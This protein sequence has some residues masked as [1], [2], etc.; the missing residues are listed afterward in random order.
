MAVEEA[1]D[2]GAAIEDAEAFLLEL[3]RDGPVPTRAI[4]A[5]AKAHGHA[6]R[7]VA[8]AKKQLGIKAIKG[9]FEAGW[10]W[11][12]PDPP[13]DANGGSNNANSL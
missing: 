12:L 6:S 5:A 1:D 10:S 4:E 13:K 7:T 8:R 9:G 11:Q 2:G 3:L